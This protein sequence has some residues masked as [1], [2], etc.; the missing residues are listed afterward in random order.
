MKIAYLMNIHPYASCT[1]IRREIVAIEASGIPVSRF[2]IRPPENDLVDEADKQEV[3]KTRYI[4]GVGIVGLLKSLIT[5]ALTRPIHFF[6]T[7]K[8]I[9][10]IGLSAEKGILFN[11]IY[12]LEACVLF[13]WV[14]EAEIDHIHVH[15]GTNSATVAM[16]SRL[17]GGPT[18]SF[19]VHGPEEFDKPQALCL[20]EKIENASLVIGVSSFGKSQ[21][22]RWCGYKHWSKIHVVHCG[23]DEMFLSQSYVPLPHEPRFV[24]IGRLSEQKGH[25]LLVEAVSQLASEGL[26]FKVILVGDGY[27]REQIEFLIETLGLKDYIEITGWATNLEVRQQILNSQVMV[28]PSFAEGL[29]V[30][31]MEAFALSRPVIS[32]HIAGIPELVKT[33]KSGWLVT[34]GSSEALASAMREAIHLPLAELAQMGKTGAEAVAKEHN[35]N[36]EAQ[37]LVKLFQTYS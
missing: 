2:A 16:L 3:G 15:F 36:H 5:I 9:I 21:L 6:K 28:I 29:P 34:P 31:I 20:K 32:T 11:L 33:R 10:K 26:K 25:L 24:C 27:L 14:T 18:Y 37:K 1:F 13:Q 8:F 19:T 7:L 30:V 12:F 4:L 35:I 22:F 23:L 17:L